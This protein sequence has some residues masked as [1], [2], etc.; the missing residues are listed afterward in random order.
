MSTT[1][2][3]DE[4]DETFEGMEQ[5]Y[6]EEAM[7]DYDA[8]SAADLKGDARGIAYNEE[9]YLAEVGEMNCYC[10]P[11]RVHGFKDFLFRTLGWMLL[12]KEQILG[13]F[14]GRYFQF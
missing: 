14:T 5:A 9:E 3:S 1:Y 13:G 4:Q 11:S 10:V 2:K 12:N 6:D 8:Q 7:G